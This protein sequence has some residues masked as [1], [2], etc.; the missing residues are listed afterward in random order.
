MSKR[1]VVFT[2][3]GY[4]LCILPPVA[5]ILNRFPLWAREGGRPVLSGMALLLLLV[6]AIPF[7]RG[8]LRAV[9]KWLESPSAYGVWLLIWLGALWLGRISEAVADIALLSTL[10]SL[11]GAFCFRLAR[12]GVADE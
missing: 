2:A 3:L 11:L 7:R 10:T 6:A 8:I 9:Q 4:L 12:G 1:R 5:A